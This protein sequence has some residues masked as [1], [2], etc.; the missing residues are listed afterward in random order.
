MSATCVDIF[1]QNASR[2]FTA[3]GVTTAPHPKQVLLFT[4]PLSYLYPVVR[5]QWKDKRR[6]GLLSVK[7]AFRGILFLVSFDRVVNSS[8]AGLDCSHVFFAKRLSFVL[9]KK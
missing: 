7:L 9:N 3:Q 1:L 8:W 2:D 5:T 4:G 6:C